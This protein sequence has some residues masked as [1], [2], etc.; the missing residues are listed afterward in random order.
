MTKHCMFSLKVY[1]APAKFYTTAGRDGRDI[2][3]VW[4]H[5]MPS[6]TVTL[7]DEQNSLDISI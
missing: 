5:V 1:Q 6:H 3:Q 2:L 7:Q 4:A